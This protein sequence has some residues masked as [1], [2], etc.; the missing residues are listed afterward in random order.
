MYRI[1]VSVLLVALGAAVATAHP[2]TVVSAFLAAPLTS[3]NPFIAAGW[4]AGIVQAFLK[5]PTVD[6]FED[7]PNAIASVRGFWSNPV[8]KVLLVMVLANL[9]SVLGTWIAGIWIATRT[10]SA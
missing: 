4:V 1:L 9:G 7:L 3:L 5:R 2:L 10:V 8:C 6:D